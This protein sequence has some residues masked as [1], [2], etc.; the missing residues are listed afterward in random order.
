M[1]QDTITMTELQEVTPESLNE[2]DGTRNPSDK[3]SFLCDGTRTPSDKNSFLCDNHCD[4]NDVESNEATHAT[5][6]EAVESQDAETE[7]V[8]TQVPVSFENINP[9][10]MTFSPTFRCARSTAG[11]V[12]QGLNHLAMQLNGEGEYASDKKVPTNDYQQSLYPKMSLLAKQI[13]D[14]Y[15]KR[16][17]TDVVDPLQRQVYGANLNG[18]RNNGQLNKSIPCRGVNR[19]M[20]YKFAQF[21]QLLSLLHYRLTFVAKRDPQYIKRYKEN[22]DEC[23]HFETLRKSCEEFCDYL[24][25]DGDD[26]TVV[27][28]W[29]SCVADA[30]GHGNVTHS[31]IPNPVKLTADEVEKKSFVQHQGGHQYQKKT[32]TSQNQK[33]EQSE[34]GWNVVGDRRGRGRGR[35]GYYGQRRSGENESDFGYTS[36]SHT[37]TG[38]GNYSRGGSHRGFRGARGRG[39][40]MSSTHV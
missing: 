28:A 13:V 4:V 15:T 21:G 24:K 38:F 25:K 1:E 16:F 18:N 26:Q 17:V 22:V 2:C 11:Q 34:G 14:Y 40:Y 12:V 3:N 39:G 6:T 33:G 27:A 37:G 7:A 5:E 20:R 31:G 9:T 29:A 35:G 36:S 19:Y 23:Q 32:Y 10:T 8:E 30:R